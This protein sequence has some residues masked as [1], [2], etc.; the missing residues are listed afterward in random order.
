MPIVLSI[1]HNIFLTEK[2][3]SQIHA[4]ETVET[5]G[6]SVPVWFY[7]GSTSEPASEVFCKYIL[8]NV[9]EDYPVEKTEKGY[10]IN[11]P[12]IPSDYEEPVKPKNW[13]NYSPHKQ[14][15]WFKKHPAPL[16][17]NNLLVEGILA[18]KRYNKT[19][20]LGKKTT[21]VHCVEIR[22]MEML[23]VSLS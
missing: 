14:S 6:V 22:H 7:R 10:R 23:E 3:R 9:E 21:I 19:I 15:Q 16:S 20:E 11:L 5:V 8:T 17:V 4:R 1:S 2:Q 12:Q 18:F 13:E